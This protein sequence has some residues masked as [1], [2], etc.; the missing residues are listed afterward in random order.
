MP[1]ISAMIRF[2]PALF[3]TILLLPCGAFADEDPGAPPTRDPKEL[4]KALKERE[5]G[6][7]LAALKDSLTVHDPAIT[8]ELLKLMKSDDRE[9]RLAAIHALS[10]REGAEKTK[11]A[12]A[13]AARLKPLGARIS[14]AEEYVFVIGALKELADPATIDELLS[15]DVN[16]DRET[17]KARLMAAAEVL[18]PEAVDALIAFASKGRNRGTNGQKDSAIQAL[19]RATGQ[20]LGS[21]P[22]KWR[23]WWKDARDRFDFDALKADREEEERLTEEKEARRAER[24]RRREERRQEDR[25]GGAGEGD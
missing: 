12:R 3:A 8:G 25:E 9:I 16:E 15:F 6:V 17:A 1:M 13:L 2:L 23:L 4:V 5:R 14:E 10:T 11:A 18:R 21:D 20:N 24:E 22:D 19:R 7:K